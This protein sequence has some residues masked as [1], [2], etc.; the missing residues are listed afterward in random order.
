MCFG[1]IYIKLVYDLKFQRD[2][3]TY[4]QLY[5]PKLKA[6]GISQLRLQDVKLVYDYNSALYITT[7]QLKL[8]G[9]NVAEEDTLEN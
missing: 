2:I 9:E 3:D 8:Y 4:S 7:S 6:N 1:K 5:F